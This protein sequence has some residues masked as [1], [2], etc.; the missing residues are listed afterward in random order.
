MGKNRSRAKK[1]VQKSLQKKADEDPSSW[2]RPGWGPAFPQYLI[3]CDACPTRVHLSDNEDHRQ[4]MIEDHRQ[5]CGNELRSDAGKADCAICIGCGKQMHRGMTLEMIK[6][7]G[8]CAKFQA[9]G[10]EKAP[11]GFGVQLAAVD[12]G[13]FA[14]TSES[15]TSSGSTSRPETT[16]KVIRFDKKLGAKVEKTQILPSCRKALKCMAAEMRLKYLKEKDEAKAAGRK[17]P[18]PEV[19]PGWKVIIR[20]GLKEKEESH[21]VCVKCD[22]PFANSEFYQQLLHEQTC[23]GPNKKTD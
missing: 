21:V 1:A 4:R 11:L 16:R 22:K 9:L 8:A 20:V 14:S 2:L 12:K 15:P 5:K 23:E 10:V 13:S 3:G 18:Q 6:H 17:P 19:R 7:E